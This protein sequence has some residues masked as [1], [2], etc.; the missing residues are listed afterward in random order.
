M[1]TA[2]GCGI[3]SAPQGE[4][5]PAISRVAAGSSTS[6]SHSP[7]PPEPAPETS[8]RRPRAS[9]IESRV[10]ASSG[11]MRAAPVGS[12]TTRWSAPFVR[13][14][15]TRPSW[16]RREP[17]GAEHPQ[18]AA[19]VGIGRRERLVMQ[20]G[21][22]AQAPEVPPPGRVVGV[23]QVVV[24]DPHRL[25][26]RVGCAVGRLAARH[27]RPFHDLAVLEPADAQL[28]AVP[29][30]VRMVP[31]DP[32]QAG[33]VG[34]QRGVGDEVAAAGQRCQTC[35]DAPLPSRRAERRRCR[36]PARLPPCG[37]RARPAAGRAAA[38]AR[39][40]GHRRHRV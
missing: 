3:H 39:R 10:T 35:R 18:R 30:H 20:V 33:A 29:R 38:S 6:S 37:L 19:G 17:A 28:G 13:A 7:A 11:R 22:E 4:P 9:S 36:A 15:T 14:A 26:R 5:P 12:I 8:T 34:R 40:S 21:R 23:E 16:Q 1:V 32:R 27:G 24:A 25:Q 31:G 2:R